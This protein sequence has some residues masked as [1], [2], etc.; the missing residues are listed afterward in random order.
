MA[1]AFTCPKCQRPVPHQD[2]ICDD[3]FADTVKAVGDPD[4]RL[5]HP[6]PPTEAEIAASLADTASRETARKLEHGES[7]GVD[8]TEIRPAPAWTELNPMLAFAAGKESIQLERAASVEIHL[9][10]QK[11]VYEKVLANGGGADLVQ[12][13]LD[14]DRLIAQVGREIADGRMGGKMLREF[15]RACLSSA[16]RAQDP[17]QLQSFLEEVLG[18]AKAD[19]RQLKLKGTTL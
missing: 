17:Q 14:R 9:A 2:M 6:E 1:V 13:L 19:R 16:D 11:V 15:V 8:T 18:A 4:P 7:T 5:T 3:C 10:E 12:A